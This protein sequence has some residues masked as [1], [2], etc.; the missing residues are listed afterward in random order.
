MNVRYMRLL[1]NIRC[2]YVIAALFLTGM[3]P[4]SVYG[5]AGKT[6]VPQGT[7]PS[8]VMPG[9]QPAA[10]TGGQDEPVLKKAADNPGY[11]DI[12]SSGLTRDSILVGDQVVW[13][14]V[15]EIPGGKS[16]AIAPYGE[17]TGKIDVLHDFRL[18]TLSIKDGIA[19]LEARL[20]FTS[21][22]SGFYRLPQPL[23]IAGGTDT[24]YF[25]PPSIAVNTI[26]I[27]TA[28]FKAYDIKGQITYPVT[29]KE[30]LPWILLGLG[31]I[32][33]IYLLYRYIKY[34]K[35]NRDFFGKPIVKDPPHII[36]LREL[37]KLRM[38]K[39]WQS[40]KEKQFYTGIA[41]TL[42]EYI[43]ARYAV[44]AM[45]KTT[46]EIMESLS[47]KQVES[48]AYNELNGL[49]KLADLVKFAKYTP[50]EAENEE[51]VPIAV[52]FVNSTFMQEMEQEKNNV[53]Q[54]EE[55]R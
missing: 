55:G 22:D 41:D 50:L 34:R 24:I 25:D 33:V 28:S 8:P 40:G 18:D 35:E 43:E 23:I 13:S 1:K 54:K 7:Q 39:L 38:Q 48:R 53:E 10:A 4:L 14:T 45:E 15:F 16:L 29:F 3:L 21:F 2:S 12:K 46:T 31:V 11:I 52:R 51:A 47:D 5:Q 37:E 36:A 49:F 27:D 30:V 20:L 17:E 9:A 26:Q 32:V 19:R 44:S 42:R 6:R